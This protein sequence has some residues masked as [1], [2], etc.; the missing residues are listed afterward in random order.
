MMF[1]W[2]YRSKPLV[3]P[4]PALVE[5][6]PPTS[7]AYLLAASLTDPATRG[8]WERVVKPITLTPPAGTELVN[9]G[10]DLR[11]SRYWRGFGD[12]SSI[13]TPFTLSRAEQDIVS[14]AM[15]SFFKHRNDERERDALT[16]L[17]CKAGKVKA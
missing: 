6:V 16:R 2:V 7:P 13:T 11:I 15:D 4:A 9:K 10:R 17:V 14:A 5:V 12:R 1:E 3:P 8:E